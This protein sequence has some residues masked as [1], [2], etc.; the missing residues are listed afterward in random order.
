M[1]RKAKPK[2]FKRRYLDSQRYIDHRKAWLAGYLTEEPESEVLEVMDI[3]T[4]QGPRRIYV[5]HL[6]RYQ[7]VIESMKE[8]K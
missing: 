6:P 5:D 1:F 8:R 7:A 4:P 3:D 2:Q